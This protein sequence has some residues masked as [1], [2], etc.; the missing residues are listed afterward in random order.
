MT[1]H[2]LTNKLF[3]LVTSGFSCG[4]EGDMRNVEIDA[5]LMELG[6]DAFAELTSLVSRAFSKEDDNLTEFLIGT[7]CNNKRQV[8]ER[9]KLAFK[10][11]SL[12]LYSP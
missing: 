3:C 11:F 4:G 9:T 10:F 8:K 5:R 2:Q 6:E 1:L 7:L 12:N